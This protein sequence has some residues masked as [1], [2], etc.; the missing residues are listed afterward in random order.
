MNDQRKTEHIETLARVAAELAGRDPDELLRLK[1]GDV[2]AF[3]DVMW[4]YPD[5]LA[6]AEAAYDVLSKADLTQC[7]L[8]TH[9]GH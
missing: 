4:R 8:S 6:R 1:L 7:A 3:D 9:G 5:F 2:V